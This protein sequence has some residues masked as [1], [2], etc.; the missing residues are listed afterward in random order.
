MS[1]EEI[2]KTIMRR[3]KSQ[4][5]ELICFYLYCVIFF[6]ISL[7]ETKR[8]GKSVCEIYKKYGVVILFGCTRW[9]SGTAAKFFA[10][11]VKSSLLDFFSNFYFSMVHFFLV[12]ILSELILENG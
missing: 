6:L 10:L 4:I 11:L 5:D 8:E 3:I 2:P 1:S 12:S 9:S 7:E